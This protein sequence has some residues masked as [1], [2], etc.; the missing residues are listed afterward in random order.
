MKSKHGE[1]LSSFTFNFNLRRYNTAELAAAARA[2]V[3]AA[4]DTARRVRGA[5]GDLPAVIEEVKAAWGGGHMLDAMLVGT[6]KSRS[7]HVINRV[8]KQRL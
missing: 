3:A 1:P 5:P 7:L 6:S 4:R 2:C 8:E